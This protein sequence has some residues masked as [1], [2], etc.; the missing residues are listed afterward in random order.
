MI[1]EH[2]AFSQFIENLRQITSGTDD[3]KA[4]IKRVRPLVKQL[5]LEKSWIEKSLYE[6]DEGQGFGVHLSHEE[7]DHSLAVFAVSWLPGRGA[8]P[9][10]TELGQRWQEWTAPKRTPFGSVWMMALSRDMPN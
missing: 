10:T 2:K 6:C 1:A 4:I 8:R 3:N 7:A 9:I 5:A